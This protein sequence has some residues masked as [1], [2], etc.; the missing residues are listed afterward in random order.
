[1]RDIRPEDAVPIF[2]MRSSGRV[3]QFIGR[4]NMSDPEAA[5]DLVKRVIQSFQEQKAIAWAGVLRGE[6]DIIG[7]CGFNNFDIPNNRAE[8]GG[9]LSVDY[10]G[11]NLAIEA[12]EAI[13]DFGF[14]TIGL[15]S[16]EAKVSPENRGAIF[17]LETLGFEK[18]AHFRDRFLH[19]GKYFDLAVYTCIRRV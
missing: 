15:H 4:D 5:E 2:K 9:E 11:K 3:N 6:G 16:I 19:H 7:T 14:N 18:E 12:V 17:L 10:W 1:M 13:V 8:I